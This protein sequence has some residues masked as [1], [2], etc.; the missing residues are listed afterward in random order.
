LLEAEKEH[1]G[2]GVVLDAWYRTAKSADWR[3]LQ[4]IRRTYSSA[5]GVPVG[6]KVFTVFNIGGNSFRLIVGV[7]YETQTIFIKH[8]L[9][10]A[11]YDKEEWKK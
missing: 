7:N 6:D 8:V 10:H 9:M 3:S 4:D 11:Q 1:R 2:I 5:D